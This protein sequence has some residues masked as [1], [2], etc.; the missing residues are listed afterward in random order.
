M[1]SNRFGKDFPLCFHVIL[2][3]FFEE[4]TGYECPR[5]H[6][7]IN[8]DVLTLSQIFNKLFE[9]S[10]FFFAD[11]SIMKKLLTKRL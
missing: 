7:K 4:F 8:D 2:I 10:F 11:I 1:P 9:N 6:T 5:Q 3:F